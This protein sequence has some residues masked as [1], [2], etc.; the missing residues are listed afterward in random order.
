MFNYKSTVLKWKGWETHWK[1]ICQDH[2]AGRDHS[3]SCATCTDWQ[4]PLMATYVL[5]TGGC[6]YEER[7]ERYKK[8]ATEDKHLHY[9]TERENIM[10]GETEIP[11]AETALLSLSLASALL[12]LKLVKGTYASRL[13]VLLGFTPKLLGMLSSLQT[14]C[15]CFVTSSLMTAAYY[16]LLP[17]TAFHDRLVI[18]INLAFV[19]VCGCIHTCHDSLH[20]RG[21]LLLF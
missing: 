7:L 4:F 20:R 19:A 6:R 18:L 16:S 3:G 14:A 10:V 21:K 11:L 12:P 1:V 9:N 17:C 13:P 8:R 2:L 5:L 15:V